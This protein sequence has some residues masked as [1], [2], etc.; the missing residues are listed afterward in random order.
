MSVNDRVALVGGNAWQA[1]K[2][3]DNALADYNE[4]IRLNPQ[5]AYT[6][7]NRANAWRSRG[8]YAKAAAD[9]RA[10]LRLKPK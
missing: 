8:E 1:E 5:D 3:Y 7:H 10:A 6:Y 2:D 4:A 9:D